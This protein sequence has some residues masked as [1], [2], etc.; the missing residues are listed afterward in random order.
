MKWRRGR[1]GELT[2]PPSD[3]HE[4]LSDV[5]AST[6]VTDV[7]KGRRSSQRLHDVLVLEDDGGSYWSVEALYASSKEIEFELATRAEHRTD[8]ELLAELGLDSDAS[9]ESISR[10][11]RDLAKRYHPDVWESFGTDE[12]RANLERM[13]RI[14]EV[15]SELRSRGR[16]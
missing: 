13:I 10:S 1:G 8:A 9:R 5:L 6:Q 3:P 12:A 4:L 11:Q 15:V 7:P 16:C 2:D 14:N